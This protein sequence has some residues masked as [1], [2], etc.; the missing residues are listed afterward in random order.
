MDATQLA[1]FAAAL[2]A[3]PT[4]A[5]LIVIIVVLY[6]RNVALTNLLIEAKAAKT[7]DA[8]ALADKAAPDKLPSE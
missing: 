2:A 7:D 5:L 1:A 8:N 6:R 3:L 4:S